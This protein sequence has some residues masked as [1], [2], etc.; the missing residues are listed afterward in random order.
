RR[1][2]VDLLF[3]AR[4]IDGLAL[5][6]A[7]IDAVDQHR[8]R[9][10]VDAA[11]FGDLGLGGA[12]NLVIDDFLGLAA[13][14]AGLVRI[15]RLAG[16]A[17]QLV[18]DRDLAFPFVG[19]GRFLTRLARAHRAALGIEPLRGLRDAVEVEIGRELHPRTPR[20]DDRCD[21]GL[22]PLARSPLERGLPL[23]GRESECVLGTRAVGQEPPGLVDDGYAL[24]LEAVYRG[25]DE[26]SDGSHLLRL[27]RAAHLEYDR[28]RCLDLF[29]GE[30]RPLRQHQMD[31]R[32]LHPV[33]RADGARELALECA[34]VI[35]ILHETGGTEGVRFVEDLIPDAAALGQARLGELHAKSRDA[36]LGDQHDDIV[37]SE[38]EGDTL[39]LEV[40]HD[41][42]GILERQVGEQRRHLGRRD[43]HDHKG[44]EPHERNRYRSHGRDSRRSQRLEK[45]DEALHVSRPVTFCPGKNCLVYGY[46]GVKIGGSGV[47]EPRLGGAMSRACLR[48]AA[49]LLAVAGGSPASAADFS[50]EVVNPFR[51]YRQGKSFNLHES[52]FNAVRG[53]SAELP[54]DII[55]RIERCLND[56]DPTHPEAFATCQG[57]AQA[58][59]FNRQ[60]G[61]ASSTLGDTCFDRSARPRRYPANCLRDGHSEDFVLPASHSVQIGLSAGRRAEAGTGDCTW[62]WKRRSDGSV[63]AQSVS[64]PCNQTV[65]IPDVPYARDRALSGVEVGVRLP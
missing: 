36:I 23:V 51:L 14:F 10:A 52:A 20:A 29:A 26:V 54:A 60:R 32:R 59:D 47:R 48:V 55:Q 40:L 63:L 35:E 57:L 44:K 2:A 6:V 18:A 12:R 43:P 8:D 62:S 45:L 64:M 15:V 31:A 30:Q 42:G 22:D 27:E 37:V 53:L 16:R 50:W 33:E 17:G 38:F 5:V 58:E 56:P 49:L 21:D 3:L 24:G 39:T 13:L 28:S 65:P 61:W 9:D 19:G 7:D 25:G 1:D 34:Q 41:R 11:A 46:C 4:L